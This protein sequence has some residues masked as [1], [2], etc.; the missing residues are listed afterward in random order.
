MSE[1]TYFATLSFGFGTILAIFAMRYAATIK[2][3]KVRT[4]ADE[5]ARI[6]IE[7]LETNL[8]DVKTRLEAIET[9]LKDVG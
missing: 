2:K 4:D 7:A 8:A 3:A 1:F 5:A 6:R 9:M